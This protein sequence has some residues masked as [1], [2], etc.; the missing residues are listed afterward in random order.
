MEK[1]LQKTNFLTLKCGWINIK[2]KKTNKIQTF[3][4]ESD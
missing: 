4:I 1:V 3:S 2:N